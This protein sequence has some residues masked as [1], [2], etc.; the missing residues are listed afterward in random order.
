MASMGLDASMVLAVPT[1]FMARTMF[2]DE[3]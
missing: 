1:C 3:K 2:R